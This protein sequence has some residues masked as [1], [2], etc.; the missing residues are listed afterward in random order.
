MGGAGR[1]LNKKFEILAKN[2]FTMNHFGQE[3]PCQDHSGKE[4]FCCRNL[5][6]EYSIRKS[7]KIQPRM[8]GEGGTQILS[9]IHITLVVGKVGG[10]TKSA[11]LQLKIK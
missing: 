7:P 2:R 10:L 9:R 11:V 8:A 5:Q 6:L 1:K 3:S 4:S